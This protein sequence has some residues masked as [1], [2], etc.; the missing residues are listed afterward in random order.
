MA[1]GAETEVILI[2]LSQNIIISLVVHATSL[3]QSYF[4]QAMFAYLLL[5]AEFF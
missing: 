4:V 1:V 2:E 5:S 3:D